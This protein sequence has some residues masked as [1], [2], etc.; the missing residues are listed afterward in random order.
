MRK[1]ATVIIFITL[2]GTGFSQYAA[3]AG[4]GITYIDIPSLVDY[5]NNQS[6]APSNQ[7]VGI[8]SSAVTFS[9]EADYILNPK[10]EIGIEA[11][12]LINSYNFNEDLGIYKLNYGIFM[13]SVIYYYVIRDK[14]YNLKFGGGVGIRFVSLTEQWP[15]TPS[16]Q[17][18]S[19]SGFGFLIRAD[20]N[21]ILSRNLFV[22]IGFD[23][24]YDFNGKPKDGNNYLVNKNNDQVVSFNSFSA[25]VRL[26]VTY[27]F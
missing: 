15:A 1:I 4:M 6:I 20:G 26:G 19:S 7:Q 11:A 8:F 10:H 16:G 12:Y 25:G 9:A 5:L 2:T 13:P 23:A 3:R 21:T 27:Y 18:Y 17:N 14:G 24:R 22:N